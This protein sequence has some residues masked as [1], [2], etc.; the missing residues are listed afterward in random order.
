MN[1]FSAS[2]CEVGLS[3]HRERTSESESDHE[4]NMI[5]D[6]RIG[7]PI[8]RFDNFMDGDDDLLMIPDEEESL[9]LK[10]DASSSSTTTESAS[11]FATRLV[12]K[13]A[14]HDRFIPQR[15]DHNDQYVNNFEAK[16]ILLSKT[17]FDC[18]HSASEVC[19]CTNVN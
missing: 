17:Q 16:E 12:P 18:K 9:R 14:K 11:S 5:N 1:H 2:F 3:S 10:N 8:K 15:Q 6:F 4:S 7:S 19:D 13:K